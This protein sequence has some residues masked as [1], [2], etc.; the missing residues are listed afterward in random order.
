[1]IGATVT[2]SSATGLVNQTVA[3]SAGRASRPARRPGSRTSGD[4]LDVNTQNPV[5]VYECRGADPASSSDC[6][7]SPG[8]RGVDASATSPA[9][10]AVPPFTYLGQTDP[11]DATPDG[12]ANWQDN[13]TR[14]DGTGEVTIQV[15]TKRE[16]AGARVR[17]PTPP[18]RS[19]W[20]R[21]TAGHRAT[22]RTCMDAP[23]AWDRRTVVPLT[24]QPVDDACP[25]GG[26]S[27][28]VEGSPMAADL[29]ASWRART[30]T[31]DGKLGRPRLH[32]DRRAADPRR[33]RLAASPT[34]A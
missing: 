9:I 20:C 22:P 1:M 16:S 29:L 11:Y 32:R 3:V 23:W 7:G 33:R 14:A 10:P 28:G 30:C 8:F 19:W 21:T 12:P 4:S 24:F 2:V 5:R 25:I 31:L 15:F 17:R 6:Y 18:A 27:L 26:P 34:S 13:V